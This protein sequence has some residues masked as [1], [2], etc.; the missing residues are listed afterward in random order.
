VIGKE[1]ELS[2]FEQESEMADR[3]EG[4]Q[5]F[6]VECGIPGLGNRQFSRKECQRSP[7]PVFQ[8]LESGPHMGVGG[9]YR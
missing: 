6:P 9:I 1:S 8:L 3:R 5:Q 2:S 4:G 7:S